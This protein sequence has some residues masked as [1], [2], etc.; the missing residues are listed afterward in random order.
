MP[1]RD[2]AIEARLQRWAQWVTAGDGSGFPAMSVLH[3]EWTP[4]SPGTTPTLKVGLSTDA[5]QTHRALMQL[6]L[7][8]KNTVVVHYCHKVPLAEQARR[9]ECAESTVTA[10]IGLIHQQLRQALGRDDPG[11][12]RNKFP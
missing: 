6:S 4:P 2:E 1:A 10:R 3:R 8:F 11:E 9:L 12:F 5:Q 7:R